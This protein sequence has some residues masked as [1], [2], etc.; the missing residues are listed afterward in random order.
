MEDV[1]VV[2]DADET[3]IGIIGGSIVCNVNEMSGRGGEAAGAAALV[4]RQPGDRC[5]SAGRLGCPEGLG[6]RERWRVPLWPTFLPNAP[7]SRRVS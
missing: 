6:V 5:V 3:D 2:E 7:I 1:E 4:R